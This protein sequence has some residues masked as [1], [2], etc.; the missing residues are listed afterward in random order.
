MINVAGL[1]KTKSATAGAIIGILLW[2]TF[3]FGMESKVK[4]P[5]S[6][7]K[8]T[9]DQLILEVV[10]VDKTFSD[11]EADI[12]IARTKLNNDRDAAAEVYEISFNKLDQN[13]ITG[14]AWLKLA[15]GIATIYATGGSIDAI[16]LIGSAFGLM[17]VGAM[18]GATVE[19][20]NKIRRKIKP[21]A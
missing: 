1:F 17:G 20:G 10:G 12:E 16:S 15:S 3:A 4:S 7:L 19:G 5:Q 8:M 14:G 11:R 18:A 6:G 21:V 2:A 13:D 9:R